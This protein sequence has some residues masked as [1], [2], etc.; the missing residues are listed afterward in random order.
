MKE[1]TEMFKYFSLKVFL[2]FYELTFVKT[3]FESVISL[4]TRQ[5]N[6]Y[7]C[8]NFSKIIV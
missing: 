4:S 2:V 6:K 1:E 7:F 8:V 5:S 3:E